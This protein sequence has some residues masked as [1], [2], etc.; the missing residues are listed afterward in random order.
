MKSS[1]TTKL[2]AYTGYVVLIVTY[3]SQAWTP[4]RSNMEQLERVQ[5]LATKWILG[6]SVTFDQ[7]GQ[8]AVSAEFRILTVSLPD[9]RFR[10][11]KDVI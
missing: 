9:W 3:A 11:D 2:N 5:K 10:T 4:S 6:T 7:N 8:N 1:V